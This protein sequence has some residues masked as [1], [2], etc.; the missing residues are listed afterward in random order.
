MHSLY[1]AFPHRRPFQFDRIPSAAGS[2]G[3]IPWK[4]DRS[5]ETFWTDKIGLYSTDN[6]NRL[7]SWFIERD[8][9]SGSINAIPVST[10]FHWYDPN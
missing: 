9:I 3:E 4:Q 7:V 10:F 1:A 8:P 5:Y 2:S 6:F